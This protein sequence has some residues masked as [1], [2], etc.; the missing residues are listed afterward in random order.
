MVVGLGGELYID[1][2]NTGYANN[3]SSGTI[4]GS[5]SGWGNAG[6]NNSATGGAA[7]S[8]VI[9]SGATVTFYGDTAAR[10][11]NGNGDH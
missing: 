11:I 3:G 2:A 1:G 4:N 9:D 5:T 6:S 7:G 8:G 10:Y